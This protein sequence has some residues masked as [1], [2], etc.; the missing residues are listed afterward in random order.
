MALN[1][2]ALTSLA[3]FKEHLNQPASVTLGDSVLELFINSASEFI[4][5]FC[6]R[7][8]HADD[9]VE[10]HS[11]ARQNILLPVQ[12]PLNSVA[13]VRLSSDRDWTNANSLIDPDDYFIFD[14]DL[15]IAFHFRL[16]V[17]TGNVRIS[18]NAGFTTIPSD[19]E[20]ACLWAAEWYYRNR[21]R[22]NI[23]KT[24]ESKGDES[25]GLLAELPPMVT[26]ILM[27]YKRTEFSSTQGPIR[28]A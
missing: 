6:E 21:S 23:G 7:K 1:A 18:Y 20:L 16:P 9:Y 28:S 25:V 12:W 10:Y 15:T 3:T 5:R 22:E 11:G 8:F 4:E 26:E 2:N 13:E 27:N 14:G 19:L 24:S 17:G